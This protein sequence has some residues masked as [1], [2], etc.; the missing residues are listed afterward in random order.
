M[1][2]IES[3]FICGLKF[4]VQLSNSPARYKKE[5]RLIIRVRIIGNNHSKSTSVCSN[6][7]YSTGGEKV[8]NFYYGRCGPSVLIVL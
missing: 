7:F 6:C 5:K 2:I 8:M 3:F 1:I 4:F